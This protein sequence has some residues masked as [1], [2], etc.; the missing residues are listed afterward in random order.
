MII[1]EEPIFTTALTMINPLILLPP[2]TLDWLFSVLFMDKAD[3]AHEALMMATYN[4]ASAY[5]A[6]SPEISARLS[7]SCG[8][9]SS[10]GPF[11]HSL[12][13]SN[14]KVE[15]SPIVFFFSFFSCLVLIFPNCR[16]VETV[17]Q[18]VPRFQE[19]H[20]YAFGIA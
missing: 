15:A 6:I 12:D 4:L 20:E 3:S 11:P 18:Q 16:V 2:M 1:I 13:D 7:S 9:I 19:T 14:W 17:A 5:G 8:G 10:C